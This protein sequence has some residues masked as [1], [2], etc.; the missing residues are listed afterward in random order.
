MDSRALSAA[1]GPSRPWVTMEVIFLP[2]R[3]MF[4]LSDV[5]RPTTSLTLASMVMSSPV[6]GSWTVTFWVLCSSICQCVYK[7]YHRETY[8]GHPDAVLK[9]VGLEVS[10]TVMGAHGVIFVCSDN[11]GIVG[12]AV[13]AVFEL[14]I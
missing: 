1:V 4:V 8:L 6:C 5:S 13:L 14:C 3:F 11:G 7:Q 10:R 9:T 12:E 2:A